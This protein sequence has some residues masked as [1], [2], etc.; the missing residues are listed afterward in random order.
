MMSAEFN[1][2]DLQTARPRSNPWLIA[3][4]AMLPTFMELLDTSVANIALRHIAGTFA[5]GA[6]ESTWVLT[7]YLVANAIILAATGWLSAF[8]G[9]QRLLLVCIVVF[10]AASALCGAAPSSSILIVARV[11]QGMGG[12][13]LQPVAQAVLLESFPLAKR[14]QAMCVYT[15]GIMVAPLVA[16][17]VGGWITE[18]WS[19]RWVFY[20]NIPVGIVGMVMTRIF[21][22]DPPYLRRVRGR[23]DYAGFAL[24]AVGLSA[25]QIVFDRGQQEDWF[26]SSLILTLFIVAV[27]TLA[28]FIFRQL[29][30]DT[31]ILDLRVLRNRNFAIGAVLVA[32]IGGAAFYGTITLV[33]LFLETMLGYT[34]ALSGQT[35][36]WRGI[37]ALLATC[38]VGH[39]TGKIDA[40]LIMGCGFGLL[41]LSVYLLTDVNL[42]VSKS[43]FLWPCIINGFAFGFI[44]APLTTAAVSTLRTEQ[45]SNATGIFNLARNLGGSIGISAVTTM[46]ARRQQWHQATLVSHLTPHNRLFRQQLVH[47]QRLLGGGQIFFGRSQRAYGVIYGALLKQ[48]TL[49]AFIDNFRLLTL[50]CLLCAPLALFFT[51][52][53]GGVWK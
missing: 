34:P 19:W 25:L 17:T 4:A 6:D 41:A 5:A 51:K 7:S 33:P 39:L 23:V 48:A 27:L 8:F 52:R 16:P 9:R 44:S 21:I 47:V 49:L 15:L 31:P 10:T 32:T 22:N 38:I 35:L 3:V 42:E 11:L 45:I 26:S 1:P 13:V 14:G 43:T 2:S 29:Y 50:L 18:H 37:G 24:M 30:A 12:G 28:L 36:A 46:L 20:I 40:R 53:N